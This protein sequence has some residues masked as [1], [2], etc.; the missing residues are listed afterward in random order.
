MAVKEIAVDTFTLSGDIQELKGALSAVRSQLSDMFSQITELDA[1]W[2]G[3]ANAEFNRQFGID[4]EN[5]ENMCRTVESLIECMEYARDQY[6]S[7]ENAVNSKV[8]SI[9]I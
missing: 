6:N 2:D 4:H 5:A 1:M 9:Q 3:P 7:C 8:A